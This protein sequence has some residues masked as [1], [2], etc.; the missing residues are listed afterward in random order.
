VLPRLLDKRFGEIG[1]PIPVSLLLLLFL[2]L[3]F[4]AFGLNN[5]PTCCS[6]VGLL[7][8]FDLWYLGALFCKSSLTIAGKKRGIFFFDLLLLELSLPLLLPGVLW[9]FEGTDLALVIDSVLSFGRNS[10][11]LTWSS[12]EPRISVEISF[13]LRI[14][15]HVCARSSREFS[16]RVLCLIWVA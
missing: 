13:T 15:T 9:S 4:L 11:A 14:R 7:P 6:T 2:L 5:H 1:P 8:Y 16:V 3:Y 10:G 12:E